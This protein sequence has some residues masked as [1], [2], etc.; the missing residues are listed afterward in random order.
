MSEQIADSDSE[1]LSLQVLP[2][3]DKLPETIIK[4]IWMK[5]LSNCWVFLY[6]ED[7]DTNSYELEL[8]I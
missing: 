2:M 1:I 8:R 5:L 4:L 6:K 7:N 3:F